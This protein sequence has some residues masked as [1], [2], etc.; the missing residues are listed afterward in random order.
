MLD[1]L[2]VYRLL[3]LNICGIPLIAKA[4]Y[5]GYIDKIVLSDSTYIS[6]LIVVVFLIGM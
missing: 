5:S 1:K 3:I 4:W 6:H 2:L